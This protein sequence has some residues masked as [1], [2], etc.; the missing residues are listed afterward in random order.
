VLEVVQELFDSHFH[1][2]RVAGAMLLHMLYLQ[3]IKKGNLEFQQRI[4]N[5]YNKNVGWNKGVNNWDLVDETAR[6]IAGHYVSENMSHED[7]KKWIDDSIE[8]KDLWVN[9]VVVVATWYQIMRGN[10][11]MCFYVVERLMNHPHDLIHKACGWMLREVGRK[12]GREV[13][14]KF[15]HT[16][17]RQLPRTCLRYSI[18]HFGESDRK[19]FLKL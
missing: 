16:H 2:V 8:S 19:L 17:I 9:R 1:E 7:R 4:F 11:K 3:A 5:L 14:S 10:E 18:E 12:C 15:I 13:L 6:D